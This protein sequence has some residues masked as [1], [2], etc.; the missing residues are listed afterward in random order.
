MADESAVDALK[1]IPLKKGGGM[2]KIIIAVA[3][4]AVLGGGGG[5]Y[6]LHQKAAAAAAA[7]AEAEAEPEGGEAAKPTKAKPKKKKPEVPLEER[8]LVP[9]EPFL[10]NLADEG[11][12][13]FLKVTVQVI[14]ENEE[15]A[16]KI[17]EKKV[18][19]MNARSA[20]LELLTEQFA[21]HLITSDGKKELK[22][23]IKE[24]VS[25]ALEQEVVDVLFSEFVVQF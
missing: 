1:P 23:G 14:V 13:R 24:R 9:F 5:W 8:G 18:L 12:N 2:K 22:E 6:Y 16:K 17:E 3:A 19:A 10:V 11:G 20:V 21:D 4:V 25:E 15:E 7:A